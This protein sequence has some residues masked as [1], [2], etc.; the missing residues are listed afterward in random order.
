MRT[1]LVSNSVT[2]YYRRTSCNIFLSLLPIDQVLNGEKSKTPYI[3][4]ED[5]YNCSKLVRCESGHDVP[6][7]NSR[8]PRARCISVSPPFRPWI[9]TE[10]FA[11]EN[12]EEIGA[13]LFFSHTPY[14]FS[15]CLSQSFHSQPT[16]DRLGRRRWHGEER[17]TKEQKFPDSG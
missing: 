10:I 8:P 7:E 4:D 6:K 1:V 17:A 13:P 5:R 3:F 2:E 14:S 9:Y 11:I 16:I 12:C 15:K